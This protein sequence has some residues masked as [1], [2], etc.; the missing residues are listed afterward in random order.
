M[1]QPSAFKCTGCDLS[2][3]RRN[4][5]D[6]AGQREPLLLIIGEAPGK[7]EDFTGMPFAG[8]SGKLLRAVLAENGFPDGTY[9]LTNTVKCRPPDN[10]DPTPSEIAAC[11]GWLSEEF[12]HVKPR[13]VVALGKIA[14]AAARAA[15]VAG[16]LSE[17]L[18]LHN[19]HHPAYILRSPRNRKAWSESFREL[20]RGLSVLP[21]STLDVAQQESLDARP[22]VP[23]LRGNP[24]WLSLYFSADIETD[25]LEEGYGV[26]TVGYSVSDG[27]RAA[28][29]GGAYLAGQGDYA[30]LRVLEHQPHTYLHNAKYDAE[31]LGIDLR[32]EDTWDCT[33]LIAYVL[34]YTRVGLKILAPEV[35]GITLDPISDIIGT[36]K[37]RIPFSHAL[38]DQPVRAR[39]YGTMDAFATARLA[40][41]L[42]PALHAI[43]VLENYY[44]TVEKPAV[45]VIKEMEQRGV[46][47]DADILAGLGKSMGE[48]ITRLTNEQWQMF[49]CPSDSFNRASNQQL[50]R[51][52]ISDG[53]RLTHKTPTGQWRLDDSILEILEP[54]HPA[55]K[56]ER[57]IRKLA[58]LKGTYVDRLQRDRDRE[59]R[60]H[61]RFNQAVTD[62]SRLSSSDPNLQ[63]IP[64]RTDL[65]KRIRTAFTAR[66]GYR[67]L[68]ADASQLEVRVYAEYTGE[69]VLLDAY[70]HQDHDTSGRKGGCLRCD[71]HQQVASQ[72]SISRDDAKNTLFAAIYGAEQ[73]RLARTAHVP[74]A[75]TASFLTLMRERLPSLLT[76]RDGIKDH[77]FRHGYIETLLGWRN[78]YPL[79]GS[80]IPSERAAALREAGNLPIQGSGAGI[81]KV[82]MTGADVLARKYEAELVLTVHDEVVYEVPEKNVMPFAHELRILFRDV[83]ARWMKRVP[84]RLDVSVGDSWGSVEEIPAGFLDAA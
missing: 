81:I 71:V 82:G 10:R 37:K 59:S 40:S 53:V 31:S 23:Y 34:R 30:D 74:V 68:K 54:F 6:G 9:Y 78:Y 50:A 15:I 48:E 7:E 79:F 4:I 41:Q 18:P 25:D 45:P 19:L 47:V 80:V 73:D 29:R 72:L 13:A 51:Q 57:S 3:S 12:Q 70:T 39:H 58:K 14:Q 49:G 46:L 76:F 44:R 66:P 75:E 60:V 21:G 33:M 22:P 11:S 43:P 64:I 84:F 83:A 24:D 69:P 1:L 17:A 52:L 28:F 62:T 16:D 67:I 61:A 38:R 8:R 27:R 42:H 26:R 2:C 56:H 36:G 65:G 5:V 77:L 20:G 32:R 35:T 63:N 55:I